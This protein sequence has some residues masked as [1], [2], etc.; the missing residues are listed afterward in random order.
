[1][2]FNISFHRVLHDYTFNEKLG[3]LFHK[4]LE[5]RGIH[6]KLTIFLFGY[7]FCKGRIGEKRG[8]EYSMRLKM[9][10]QFLEA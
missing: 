4:Y 5:I 6:P 1:M 3:K 10:K 9:L 8:R 7:L 2:G